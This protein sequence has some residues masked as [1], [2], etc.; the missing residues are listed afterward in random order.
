MV[1]AAF[2]FIPFDAALI[3]MQAIHGIY[4]TFKVSDAEID[5]AREALARARRLGFTDQIVREG[6]CPEYYLDQI[7]YRLPDIGV[8]N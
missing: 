6:L 5:R 1:F 4:Q 2:L 8:V 7:G 3:P